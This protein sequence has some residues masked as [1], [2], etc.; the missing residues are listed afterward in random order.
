MA[1]KNSLCITSYSLCGPISVQMILKWPTHT[2][3]VPPKFLTLLTNKVCN[4]SNDNGKLLHHKLFLFFKWSLWHVISPSICWLV[5]ICEHK[6][7]AWST[8]VILTVRL[9]VLGGLVAASR[10]RLWNTA[11]SYLVLKT[12]S[13]PLSTVHAIW[14]QL[15]WSL[16]DRRMLKVYRLHFW[17]HWTTH[18]V[19]TAATMEHNG[20][21]NL[22]DLFGVL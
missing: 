10:R 19:A 2:E 21:K 18:F 16:N 20:A 4:Y 12:L 14:F 9:L 11:Q 8:F 15:Q 1:S 17:L 7:K 6:W 3:V 13:T 22:S 5:G